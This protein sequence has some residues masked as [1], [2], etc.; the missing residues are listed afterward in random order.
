MRSCSC[1]SGHVATTIEALV[2]QDADRLD[3][4]G[5]IG[6]ARVFATGA[7]MGDR[8]LFD[9]EKPKETQPTSIGHFYEKLLLLKN[10]M[11]TATGRQMAEDRHLYLE[12]FLDEF[13]AEWEGIK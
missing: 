12:Q 1:S 5:A 3:A 8:M 10:R 7:K 11:N 13:Y 9:P 6:I 4:L 2:V